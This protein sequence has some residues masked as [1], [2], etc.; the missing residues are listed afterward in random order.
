MTSM[1]SRSTRKTPEQ[2]SIAGMLRQS[3]W[4]LLLSC[5]GGTAG[6]ARERG[7]EILECGSEWIDTGPVVSELAQS[8]HQ[9]GPPVA[10]GRK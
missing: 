3:A 8:R 6:Y 4:G 9:L 1:S 2:R 7:K 5:D 10:D